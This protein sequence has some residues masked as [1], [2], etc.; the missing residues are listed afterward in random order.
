MNSMLPLGRV[1]SWPVVSAKRTPPS[2]IT[3]TV[4]IP[5]CGCQRS[6]IG[7]P[8]G[9]AHPPGR[10]ASAAARAGAIERDVSRLSDR[11]TR[12]EVAR[13]TVEI[14]P[15]FTLAFV[16]FDD[17]GRLWSREQLDLLDRTLTSQA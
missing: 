11:S 15:D 12:R 16:E 10:L 5:E 13:H 3:V 4:A 7:A 8:A 2:S 14:H 6:S 17:Q 1:P 9:V